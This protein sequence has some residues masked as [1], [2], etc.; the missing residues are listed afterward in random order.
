MKWKGG[1]S[2]EVTGKEHLERADFIIAKQKQEAEQVKAEQEA[3]EADRDA[4]LRETDEAKSE[5][6]KLQ[7]VNEEKQRRSE[8]LDSEIA[9]KEEQAREVDRENTDSIKSGIANLFGKGKYAAIE[10]ENAR[11]KAENEHIKESFPDAVRKEVA[12]RAKVLTNAKRTVELERDRVLWQ[13]LT[14]LNPRETRH[15]GSYGSRRPG[16]STASAWR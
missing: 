12:K 2:K 16:N 5:H 11:L 9:E 15:C 13:W 7:I 4:A 1:T 14:L 8:E 10:Q 3:A 6:E